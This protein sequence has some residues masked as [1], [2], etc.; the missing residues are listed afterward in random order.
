MTTMDFGTVFLKDD[1]SDLL[2]FFLFEQCDGRGSRQALPKRAIRPP[3]LIL[4]G[5]SWEL[6][7][8]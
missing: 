3:S 6:V 2:V 4:L 1:V 5:G 8:T 7:A